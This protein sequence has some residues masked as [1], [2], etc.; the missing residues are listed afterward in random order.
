MC[1][2]LVG[3]DGKAHVLADP[4][5]GEVARVAVCGVALHGP[6]V[7]SVPPVLDVCRWC[8]PRMHLR[9]SRPVF[10]RRDRTAGRS[11]VER[12]HAQQPLVEQRSRRDHP[13]PRERLPATGRSPYRR[14][15]AR[16][17]GPGMEQEEV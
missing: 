10:D 14:S 2:W 7:F 16:P 17:A 13:R 11:P 5:L 4:P 1:G 12:G 15:P 3:V 9:V 6:V 8:A